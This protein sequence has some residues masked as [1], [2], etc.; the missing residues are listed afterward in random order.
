MEPPPIPAYKIGFLSP[1]NVKVGQKPF[2]KMDPMKMRGDDIRVKEERS[3]ALNQPQIKH[4]AK[5]II[6]KAPQNFEN[7]KT[8]DNRVVYLRIPASAER[9][10]SSPK[11]TPSNP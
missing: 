3:L 5:T 7:L 10:P 6:S 4:S 11:Y 9:H 8:L 1:K 2:Q